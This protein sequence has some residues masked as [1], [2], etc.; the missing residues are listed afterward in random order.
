MILLITTLWFGFEIVPYLKLDCRRIIFRI[1]A[2]WLVGSIITSYVLSITSFILPIN[3]VHTILI[4]I[5]QCISALILKKKKNQIMYVKRS[6]PWLVFAFL[7]ISGV[8]LKYLTK[9]YRDVPFKIPYQMKPFVSDELSFINSI[10]FGCNSKRKDLFRFIDPRISNE[11]YKGYV[12]PLLFTAADMSLDSNYSISSIFICFF[13]I[14]CTT[15]ALYDFSSKFTRY[16]IISVIL[17][18]FSGGLALYHFKSFDSRKDF[19]NDLIHQITTKYKTIWYHPLLEIL[20]FSKMASFSIP[21]AIYALTYKSPFLTIL[22]PSIP[23]SV[24]VSLTLFL[25]NPNINQLVSFCILFRVFPLTLK[26]KPIF[27]EEM[28]RGTFYSWIKIWIEVFGPFILFISFSIFYYRIK[29]IE[30]FVLLACPQFLLFLFIREGNSHFGNS[31]VHASIFVPIVYILFSAVQQIALKDHSNIP[32]IKGIILYSLFFIYLFTIGGFLIS[33]ARI[34][35]SREVVFDNEDIDLSN[36]IIS[37]TDK[38]SIFLAN[39]NI[40]HPLILTGRQNFLSIDV[41]KSGQRINERITQIHEL[42]LYNQIPANWLQY[43]V[44][45]LIEDKFFHLNTSLEIVEVFK[46]KKY[47]VNMLK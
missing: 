17:F 26:Y 43:R 2:G 38:Q 42:Q 35:N 39:S 33:M 5:M 6:K 8:S 4:I 1:C 22:I 37:K 13:N 15:F 20:A 19:Q 10:L 21:L 31:V 16:S 45:Y 32:E 47:I 30:S 29:Q 40:T 44:K 27:Y 3:A 34:I 7:L 25:I 11:Y 14:I 9:I 46:N 36:W 18:L 23:T 12:S 28:M 41:W 24:S